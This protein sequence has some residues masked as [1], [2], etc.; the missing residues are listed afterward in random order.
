MMFTVN[1][2]YI[3]GLVEQFAAGDGRPKYTESD[4][5][6]R[7]RPLRHWPRQNARAMGAEAHLLTYAIHER[8]CVGDWTPFDPL[9]DVGGPNPSPVTGPHEQTAVLETCFGPRCRLSAAGTGPRKSDGNVPLGP[10]VTT[11]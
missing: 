10:P 1:L 5:G 7:F 2:F 8:I 6:L 11:T 3:L 4:I 9:K